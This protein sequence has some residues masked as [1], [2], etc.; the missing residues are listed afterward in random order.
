MEFADIVVRTF[1]WLDHRYPETRDAIRWLNES[2]RGQQSEPLVI[3]VSEDVPLDE[4]LQ[5]RWSF[6]NS[7]FLEGLVKKTNDQDLIER[8]NKYNKHFKYVR[9]SIP[10]SDRKIIFEPFNPNKPCLVLVF[11]NITYFDDIDLFLQEVFNIY[12]WYLRVHMIEPRCVKVTLQF[13]A[14]MEQFLQDCIDKKCEAVKHYAIMH[15]VSLVQATYLQ[16]LDRSEACNS[17]NI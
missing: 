7:S 9:R 17:C 5:K 4:Q 2:L 16:R 11:K 15:I 8:M 6:T 10:I 13:D 12:R 3:S 1:R 14:S